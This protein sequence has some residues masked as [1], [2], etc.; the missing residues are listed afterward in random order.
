[1]RLFEATP[2]VLIKRLDPL[3]LVQGMKVGQTI[4]HYRILKKLGEGGM[5]V[6]YKA[7]D[8]R[9]DR[10]V[11]LKFLHQQATDSEE[12]R[13]RLINEAKAAA[14][15]QHANICTVHEIGEA[16]GQTFIA[17]AYLEGQSLS[18]KIGAGPLPPAEAVEL[19]IQIGQGLQEAH[20]QGVVH[21]DL[22]PANIMVTDQGQAVV[23]D[24][25]LAQ[26]ADVT[27][28]TRTGTTMGTAAYMSPEQV[29]GEAVDQRADIWALGTVLYETLT[30]RP[31]F[32]GDNAPALI[33]SVLNTE[34]TLPSAR[35]AELPQ[36]LDAI[37][38]KALAK[39]ADQRYQQM[40]DLVADLQ[41]LHDDPKA[42]PAGKRPR[43][44]LTRGQRWA[45]YG[46][47]AAVLLLLAGLGWHFWPGR[48]TH[49]PL[50]A[51]LAVLPLANLSGGEEHDDYADG[52]TME[53]TS[54]LGRIADLRVVSRRSAMRYKG[55]DK[56]VADIA[57]ELH[58]DALVE[59]SIQL[60][61]DRI[62]ITAE[63]I[64]AAKDK[65]LWSD[66]F[67]SDLR[68]VMIL[69]RELAR[70]IARELMVQ[71]TPSEEALLAETRRVDPE[72]Y[73]LYLKG[74]LYVQ[75]FAGGNMYTGIE[76]LKQ[77]IAKDPGY[78]P[79]YATLALAYTDAA[80]GGHLQESE[81]YTL[82]K[83]AA[84]HAIELDETLAEAHA[85]LGA[86][87]DHHDQDWV[88]RADRH[89]R[90]ALELDPGSLECMQ[91][92][93]FFLNRN[94][95]S[96]EAI[97]L[98][99]RCMELDPISA[100]QSKNLFYT[101]FYARQYDLARAQADKTFE[102]LQLY[103][104]AGTEW[105]VRR[106]L[107]LIEILAGNYR[108]AQKQIDKLM[109]TED[110]AES[111][112]DEYIDS[113]QYAQ[114]LLDA[115][116]GKT[117]SAR[118]WLEGDHWPWSKAI[119]A[120]ALGDKDLAFENLEILYEYDKSIIEFVKMAPDLDSLHGDP[121]FDDLLRRLGFS[122]DHE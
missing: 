32:E 53:L 83:E 10:T 115:K 91:A 92:Y 82:A 42:F 16:E 27:R 88:S 49:E 81:A 60:A 101:Y 26:K 15:L 44:R 5:G 43:R 33:Y 37:V 61:G 110:Y 6:V 113:A 3:D 72:V 52:L 96:A 104:D 62:Y 97:A 58:V 34:P 79:A 29:R 84:N 89:F 66:S 20:A 122:E 74:K 105:L 54:V 78:A 107:P 31:P 19:A 63:L 35:R 21:R 55:S 25:G 46:A 4:S 73:A 50:I 23:M 45:R 9:L 17:M 77:A 90:R 75:K 100:P 14:A 13:L 85:A 109:R 47:L 106:M 70:H 121:R 64:D 76:Y 68:D 48:V 98:S 18:E 24:F 108:E 112:K 119:V 80:F 65:I 39:Q 8:T 40:A 38:A 118:A 94:A 56:P 22:K 28:L 2:F 86:S 116:T 59:G 57:Q 51:S 120:A 117:E 102:L 93:T 103:P 111:Y 30:G 99:R 87:L 11:A 114:A 12:A 69:Q 71:L 95:R 41:A 1:V 36:G 7:A 67:D